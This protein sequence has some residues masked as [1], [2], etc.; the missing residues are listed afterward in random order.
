MDER[1]KLD[2]QQLAKFLPS[3]E[4][5]RAF[6]QVFDFTTSTPATLEEVTAL[7]SL[8][9][10]VANQA[11]ASLAIYSEQ[12]E[13]LIATPATPP[14]V[15]LDDFAPALTP[16]ILGTLSEQDANAVAITGGAID[17]TTV[18]T[19]VAS[20]GAF[21]TLSASAAVALSPA[22]ANVVLAPAGTG[23]VTIAPATLG[24]MD[25]VTIGGTTKAA[26]GFTTVSTTDNI[27]VTRATG[28]PKVTLTATTGT[29]E[30]YL[31]LINTGGGYYFGVEN[32]VG[33]WFGATA[34]AGVVSAPAGKVIQQMVGGTVSTTTSGTGFKVTGGF[35]CNSKDEQG[36]YASGGAMDTTAA[37]NIAPYGFATAAQAD[38]IATKLNAIQAAL[39]ANGIMS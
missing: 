29:N 24:A 37:T 1:I 2:R 15:E 34:Y 38:S 3:H 8:A 22:N 19:T 23:L 39:V 25:N 17:G 21:T 12:L 32:S 16:I 7:A 27:S 20:S 10:S 36:A 5:I 9:I 11:L 13:L 26:G 14:A 31:Q 18:G 6:E 33:S 28:V 35:G 30:T 4:A